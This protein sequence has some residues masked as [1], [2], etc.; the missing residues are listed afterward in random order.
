VLANRNVVI[1][2]TGGIAAYKAVELV[3]R[4]RKAGAHVHVIMTEHA[5]EF[6]APLTFQT[7]SQNYVVTD[8]FSE[9]RTWD[10]EHI[11]LAKKADLLVIVPASANVIGKLANGIADDMLT[12]TT[13]A[14][15]APVMLVP[16][17]NTNMYLNPVV[18]RNMEALK[19]LG[20]RFIDPQSGRLACADVG[21]GKMAE[22]ETIFNEIE[23]FFSD[24][25]LKGFRMLVTAGPTQEAIDPVRYIT[26]HSSGKM[27]YAIAGQAARR[28]AEVIL[29]SGKTNL[30]V[31]DGVTRVDVLT[32]DEMYQTL[33][34]EYESCDAII[35]AAAVADY[36]PK[37]VAPG[38]I[39]K[40]GD[41]LTLEL[42]KNIDI[43][44]AFGKI[45]GNRVFVGFA[46]ET[47]D[48]IENAEAKIRKKNFDMIVANDVSKAGAGFNSETNIVTLIDAQGQQEALQMMDKKDVADHI[49]DRI[50]A[51][52]AN[53]K[54]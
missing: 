39:K 3:S 11:A 34:R 13:M 36:R 54:G 15:K 19:T 50:A 38:K 37:T 43:A 32:A 7:L 49:L 40:T 9:P 22:P 4:L 27:G 16:A 5:A 48:L 14:T 52:L 53:R 47:N 10:V 28:G 41:T 44:E 12:T 20:Y 33:L 29:I 42:V 25:D 1:G 17:M 6:V 21:V 31:P 24:G 46:A 2:V 30:P 26:N 51:L 35:K 23:A 45:K 18:Q 8:M